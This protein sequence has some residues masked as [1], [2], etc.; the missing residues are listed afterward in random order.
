MSRA[1]EERLRRS[2]ERV[3]PSDG[4]T[5]EIFGDLLVDRQGFVVDTLTKI[6]S[7]NPGIFRHIVASCIAYP[8]RDLLLDWM[9]MYYEIFS[10]SA[11]RQGVGMLT[12]EEGILEQIVNKRANSYIVSRAG[13]QEAVIAHLELES[14]KAQS[15]LEKESSND[16]LAVYWFRARMR[17]MDDPDHFFDIVPIL[18]LSY[19][20]ESQEEINKQRSL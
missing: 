9:L 16:D 15:L 2:L 8:N 13:G 1:E 14:E 6:K 19:I 17:E 20:F 10:R 18:N 3:T 5:E 12:V 4:I 7:E 11:Q